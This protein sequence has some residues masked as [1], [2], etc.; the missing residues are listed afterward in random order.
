MIKKTE[1]LSVRI[2]ADTKAKLQIEAD[3][4]ERTLSDYVAKLLR[5]SV[6][7]EPILM[8]AITFKG[9]A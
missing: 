7:D 9:R 1:L 4:A 6:K 3:K 8:D 5:D 2:D